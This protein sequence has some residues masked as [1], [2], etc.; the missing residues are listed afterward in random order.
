MSRDHDDNWRVSLLRELMDAYGHDV[1]R[2]V[3]GYVR[4]RHLAE[5][6]SQEVFV[7]VYDHLETFRQE[8]SYKTW[9]LR[10]AANRAKDYLRSS[11]RRTVPV[12]DLSHI[13]EDRSVEQ[14]VIA[15]DENA[16][17]WQ[18]VSSLP[19]KY[20]ETILLFYG[21]EMSI[22]EIAFVTE[23]SP[24]SV[25]TRLHRGRELLRRNFGRGETDEPSGRSR[26]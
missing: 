26:I 5:D 12:D 6:I 7:K 16:Y 21:H 25:K 20:R 15:K 23:V 1:I 17:L 3:F 18:M 22:D 14:N 13:A 2:L 9:I 19:D 4:D 24:A 8:S 11:A 10:I